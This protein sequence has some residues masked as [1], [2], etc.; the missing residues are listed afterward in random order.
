MSNIID[1]LNEFLESFFSIKNGVTDKDHKH[2]K[3][4]TDRLNE[5]VEKIIKQTCARVLRKRINELETIMKKKGVKV[6]K[7]AHLN[8]DDFFNTQIFVYDWFELQNIHE[9]LMH[10]M[11]YYIKNG[12]M[13][14]TLHEMGDNI[15]IIIYESEV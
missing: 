10:E 8:E 5:E 15:Q 14:I 12:Y 3:L 6:K 1:S 9:Q 13:E 4:S 11:R 7:Y 2:F